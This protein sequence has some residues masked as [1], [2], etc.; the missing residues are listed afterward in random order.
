MENCAQLDYRKIF[1]GFCEMTF[2]IEKSG[3]T[4]IFAVETSKDINE[5][6]I[7]AVKNI[8]KQ[9]EASLSIIL[10]GVEGSASDEDEDLPFFFFLLRGEGCYLFFTLTESMC[11]FFRKI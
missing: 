11:F 10:S 1:Y 9:E 5:K 7:E 3:K 4:T 6:A 2:N 8:A